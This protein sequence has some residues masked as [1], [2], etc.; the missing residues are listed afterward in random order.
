MT[1]FDVVLF[2]SKDWNSHRQRCHWVAS[3]LADRGA[4]VLF[5]ENLGIRLP[6]PRDVKRVAVKLRN[7]VATSAPGK[8]RPVA[9]GIVLDAPI[10]PPLQHLAAVRRACDR[11]L[12]RRLQRRLPRRGERPLLV[13]TYIPMPVV[14]DVARAL[15]ADALVFEWL[16]DASA[17]ALTRSAGHRRRLARWEDEMAARADIVFAASPEL[18]RR[19]RPANPDT[20]VVPHGA[21]EMARGVGAGPLPAPGRSDPLPHVTGPRV[22]FVGSVTEFTDLDLIGALASARPRWSFVVVGPSRVNVKALQRFPNVI[23]TGQ[24]SHDEVLR[25]LPTFSAAIVPYR[26]TPA[27]E[28]AS[29]M[30]VPEY[31]AFDLPVVSVDVPGVRGIPGVEIV[32]GVEGFLAALDKAVARAPVGERTA[33]TPWSERVDEMLA[34]MVRTVG[35]R[36]GRTIGVG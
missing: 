32:S 19:R 5:V 21:P 33:G 10:V 6:Q 26:L 17:H 15:S 29:P 22:G 2:A 20:F 11:A 16:D 35:D 7:W 1:S 18:L 8:P 36:T 30:K 13:W 23:L 3:E 28:V 12:V 4:Q 25:L 27:T 9:P 31:L 24:R 14:A 34:H